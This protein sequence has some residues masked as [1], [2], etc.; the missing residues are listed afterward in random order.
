MI[1]ITKEGL[2]K[3]GDAVGRVQVVAS[4]FDQSLTIPIEVKNIHYILTSLEPSNVKLKQPE[5]VIPQG[6]SLKLKVSMH[7]N[8]GNEFSHG[9]EEINTLK[10]KMS[11]KGN[12]LISTGA[13]FSVGLNL[14][15][16]TSD[17]LLISLKDKTGVKYGEDY[18]KLVVGETSVVFPE[19]TVF[20]VG[21]IICFESPL[22]G[23]VADWYS[24]DDNLVRIDSASGIARIVSSRRGLAGGEEKV[25]INHGDRSSGGL[26]FG[27][28][29]LEADR[30][31]FF[32]SYDIFNGQKYRAHLVIKN[33]QQL[34]KFV[35]VIAKNISTCAENIESS[36]SS[37]FSCKV[38]SKQNPSTGLLKHFKTSSSFDPSI[39]AYTCDI[40]LATSIDE[41][42]NFVK[43][44]EMNIE[45]EGRLVG[46]GISDSTTLKIVPAVTVEPEAISIEQIGT[47]AIS[48]TGI[49]KVLQ[50]LEV[51]PSNPN[52]LEVLVSHKGP[53]TIQYKLRLLNSYPLGS[54]E[55]LY[56]S[57]NS[58][59]TLQNVKIPIQSPLILRKCASQ[60]LYSVPNMFLN[61][62]S[63]FGLLISALI[64]LAATVWVFVFCFPQ[65]QKLVDP[66]ATLIYSPF[67]NDNSI[68]SYNSSGRLNS[69]PFA[70]PL[71][72]R[73]SGSVQSSSSS[74]YVGPGNLSHNSTPMSSS[75]F[76]ASSSGSSP[77]LP[78][79]G[80]STLLSPQK[81][82]HR[83]QL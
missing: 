39:G 46:S 38:T 54:N 9:I 68:S 22:L 55:E 73:G 83:R 28:D 56:V 62:V 30:I 7:D 35:N 40:D 4:S 48:V 50:K 78:I 13:N 80:D 10:H 6:I 12:V 72:K 34:D 45:L 3:S 21:D 29:V 19:K 63:N 11:R 75:D 2:L 57:V 44:S 61:Y 67:K 41:I 66:N 79:Y 77:G 32:K 8:L 81:R 17:M 59:L 82:I 31:E 64:V 5:S 36:F 52:M 16:E 71:E 37:L 43:S 60:P 23:T 53:G 58:P 65:R 76:N 74:P 20:S 25:F 49:E 33:H 24:S 18:L 47:Q 1:K 27:I 70:S 51:S 26:R 15:R 14:I 69:S 42:T